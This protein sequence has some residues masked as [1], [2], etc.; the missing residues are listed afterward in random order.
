MAKIIKI[1]ILGLGT[2]GSAIP[3]LLR[4]Q[5]EKIQKL[6]GLSFEIE[7]VFV[8]NVSNKQEIA[9]Q[10][11]LKLTTDIRDVIENQEIDII[12]EVMG[13]TTIA[14]DSIITALKNK[15]HVITANKDL[16]AQHG[17]EIEKI[18]RENSCWLY[19]EAAVAGGIP[20]L[21]TLSNSFISDKINSVYGIVNGT[22][23]YMLTQ[24]TTNNW[25]YDEALKEAQRLGFAESDP[26]N[27]VE[28]IDAAYKMVILTKLCFGMSLQMKDVSTQGI[29]QISKQDILCA[30]EMGYQIKLLGSA[31]MINQGVKTS[32]A[33]TLVSNSHPLASV[34]NEKNAVFI[35]SF[36]MGET[37]YYGA[38]AGGNPTASSILNDLM[39]I[40]EQLKNKVE[41]SSVTRFEESVVLAAES[42]SYSKYFVTFEMETSNETFF[43]ILKDKHIK[44]DQI[45]QKTSEKEQVFTAIL[46]SKMNNEELVLLLEEIKAEFKLSNQKSYH[47]I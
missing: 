1:G 12:V 6:T 17:N 8:R 11:N 30:E 24:M 46:T 15:K 20:I 43:N 25:S 28:G 47:V 13:G 7:K 41:V 38:G 3:F 42:D 26:T 2:V 40:G 37:M 31:K 4:E 23:N 22:T 44:K 45:I 14:K 34:E 19:Y 29:T 10:F 35:D 5:E 36:G 32:V 18:A 27:D 9:N 21:R 39:V 16:I 33:P